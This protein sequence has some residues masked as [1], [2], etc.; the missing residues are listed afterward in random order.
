MTAISYGEHL[1]QPDPFS[2]GAA[3]VVVARMLLDP[4]YASRTEHR[5]SDEVVRL[6][7][8]LVRGTWLSRLG[9]PPWAVAWAMESITGTDH[10][11]RR[12]TW[13]RVQS[14]RAPMPLLVGNAEVPRHYLLITEV[15]P[16]SITVYDPADG[17]LHRISEREFTA[18]Q[19]GWGRWRSP[20]WLVRT[21][22][23][24]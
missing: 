19:L 1:K 22:M 21:G 4:G 11:V 17:D 20:L 23:P 5:F 14:G 3:A 16:D 13:R 6:H 10:D 24:A 12:A 18:A 9:T 8:R 7:A 2:C 15:G